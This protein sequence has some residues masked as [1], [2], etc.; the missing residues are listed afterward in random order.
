MIEAAF[1][2]SLAVAL[3]C[4]VVCVTFWAVD[5]NRKL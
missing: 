3:M 5:P 1:I 2:Y 4:L